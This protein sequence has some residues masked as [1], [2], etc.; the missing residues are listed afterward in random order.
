MQGTNIKKKS[1]HSIYYKY[2]NY[3]KQSKYMQHIGSKIY[4]YWF[5]CSTTMWLIALKHISA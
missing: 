5:S 2:Y 3:C 4:D 1:L